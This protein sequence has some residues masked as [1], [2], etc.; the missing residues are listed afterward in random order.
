MD[1]I[2]HPSY[3][4]Q[5]H[6]IALI[7]WK[8]TMEN[9]NK[10]LKRLELQCISFE[11]LQTSG[12]INL[13]FNLKA[14][15]KTSSY[16]EFILKVSNP[17]CYWKKHRIKNEVNIM[18]YLL[19]HTTIPLPK[20]FDYSVD[21]KTMSDQILVKTAI[22][23]SDY[24]KQLRQIKLPQTNKIGS[25]CS[26]EMFLGGSIEDGPTLGP[27]LTLKE[28]IIEHLRWVIRRIQ[29]DEQLFEI[30]EHLIL[31]L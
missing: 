26:R 3:S 19:E 5:M 9:M 16:I 31:S 2:Q 11:R 7:L 6:D 14:H 17:H 24:V 20:I 1:F 10:L 23:M 12:R 28:Y 27:F 15:T 18:Q 21:F 25:F 4:E 29:T 13:I 8:L 22:E 30:G